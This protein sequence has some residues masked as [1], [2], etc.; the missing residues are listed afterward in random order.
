EGKIEGLAI[1]IEEGR[2]AEKIQVA[3]NMIDKGFDIETIKIV[4]CLSDKEIEEI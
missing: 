2:K 3:K 4:T 1:G